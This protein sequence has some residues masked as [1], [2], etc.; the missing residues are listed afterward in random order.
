MF[1]SFVLKSPKLSFMKVTLR[2]LCTTI[3]ALFLYIGHCHAQKDRKPD[4][5]ILKNNTKL[6][7]LIQDVGESIKYKKLTDLNGPLFTVNKTDISSILYGNGD[8]ET[9]GAPEQEVFYTNKNTPQPIETNLRPVHKTEFDALIYSQNPKQLR[10]SYQY[11]RAKSKRGLALGIVS[12]ILGTI[13]AGV[14]T[15]LIAN[16]DTYYGSSYYNYGNDNSQVGAVLLIGGL[17]AGIT[18]GTI[19]FVKAGKNGSKATR[20]KRELVRRNESISF[21]IDP[22]YNPSLQAGYLSVKMSF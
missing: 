21:R 4:I 10:K 16:S 22:G 3:L 5:I 7:V 19:G 12:S 9:F 2:I 8:V 6:E 11:Y 15:A 14:G 20:I 1:L 17:A 13:S 18:F